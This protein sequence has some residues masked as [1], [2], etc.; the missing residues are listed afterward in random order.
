M[1]NTTANQRQ[2]CCNDRHQIL[3][4]A[5][6]DRVDRIASW[7]AENQASGELASVVDEGITQLDVMVDQ[8][9]E[10]CVDGFESDPDENEL[11]PEPEIVPLDIFEEEESEIDDRDEDALWMSFINNAVGQISSE[12]DVLYGTDPLPLFRIEEENINNVTTDNSAWFP[13]LNKE[14]LIASL[15]VGYLHKLISRD[16][17]HQFRLV[18]T[19][20]HI[21]LPRWEAESVFGQPMFGLDIKELISDDLRNPL[22]AP[23]LEFVP[24][25]AHGSKIYKLSQSAKWLKHLD[26]DL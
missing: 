18:P 4:Q 23:H 9:R 20:C 15:L 10:T 17:Y 6:K 13:F 16:L 7:R 21:K 26:S 25:E 2:H 14:Y 1:G 5:K 3:V 11:V 19:L 24:E 22:V 12:P 8:N